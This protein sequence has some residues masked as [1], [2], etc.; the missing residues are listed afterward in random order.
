MGKDKV[1]NLNFKMAYY[2]MNMSQYGR[3]W[4]RITMMYTGSLCNAAFG[5]TKKLCCTIRFREI[6]KY[7]G[8]FDLNQFL[9]LALVHLNSE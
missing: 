5:S 2:H 7:V 4:L 8:D 6:T 9:Q 1:N 3:T